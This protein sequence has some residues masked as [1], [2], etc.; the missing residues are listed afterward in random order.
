MHTNFSLNTSNRYI[1]FQIK[2]ALKSK[3]GNVNSIYFRILLTNHHAM[4]NVHCSIIILLWRRENNFFW[5]NSS[6]RNANPLLS[7]RKLLINDDDRD[8][9]GNCFVR[10]NVLCVFFLSLFCFKSEFPFLLL[11]LAENF[12]RALLLLW[13]CVRQ[14]E[15]SIGLAINKSR[16]ISCKC[17]LLPI[18]NFNQPLLYRRSPSAVEEIERTKMWKREKCHRTNH[19]NEQV[20][21]RAREMDRKRWNKMS[22][23]FSFK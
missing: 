2:R 15:N 9:I 21:E 22:Y 3:I 18:L 11:S 10:E 23:K 5:R 20:K 13:W 12:V 19:V 17:D 16:S 6:V 7:Y 14:S 8:L 4:F 1:F